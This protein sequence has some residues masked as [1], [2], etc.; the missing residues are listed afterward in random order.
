[1]SSARSP[2]KLPGNPAKPRPPSQQPGIAVQVRRRRSHGVCAAPYQMR[3]RWRCGRLRQSVA[4]RGLKA[5]SP[6]TLSHYRSLAKCNSASSGS[7]VGAKPAYPPLN[8]MTDVARQ[9]PGVPQ[10]QARSPGQRRRA[11]GVL[12]TAG[13][14]VQ[15]GVAPAVDRSFRSSPAA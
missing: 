12:R 4:A 8:V 2:A 3:C 9:S 6:T 15:T 11:T 1:M 5:P 7:D 10:R 13:W 14:T